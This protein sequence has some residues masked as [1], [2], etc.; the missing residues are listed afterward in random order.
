MNRLIDCVKRLRDADGRQWR[1]D[2]NRLMI[3]VGK[4]ARRQEISFTTEGDDYV[5]TSVILG[6]ARV[7]KNDRQRRELARLA[8][9]R[10]G[11]H[12]VVTF[13]FDRHDR[14]VGQIRHPAAQLDDAELEFYVTTLARECDRFEYLLSGADTF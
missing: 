7:T 12:E 1:L 13:A 9:Q 2:G 8:W 3:P 10:N 5:M 11:G 6:A 14:L 4:G